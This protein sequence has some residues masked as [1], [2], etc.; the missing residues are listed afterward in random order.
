[1]KNIIG[2]IEF[3]KG[4]TFRSTDRYRIVGDRGELQPLIG[5][6]FFEPEL[7]GEIGIIFKCERIEDAAQMALEWFEKRGHIDYLKQ[8]S[9]AENENENE[10]AREYRLVAFIFPKTDWTGEKID[11]SA[12]TVIASKNDLGNK[13]VRLDI[14]AVDYYPKQNAMYLTGITT[15]LSTPSAGDTLEGWLNFLEK[16]KNACSKPV[17]CKEDFSGISDFYLPESEQKDD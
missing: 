1:M 3:P 4:I 9:V 15:F 8:H 11:E 5:W 14:C 6:E 17:L 7:M 16:T 10:N 12:R 2:G 13:N